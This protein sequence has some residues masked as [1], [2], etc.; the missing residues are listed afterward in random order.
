MGRSKK[1]SI[2]IIS[3]LTLFVEFLSN[4]FKFL[5]NIGGNEEMAYNFFSSLDGAKEFAELIFSKTKVV[6]EKTNELK[7][8]LLSVFKSSI[9][10]TTSAFNKSLFTTSSS[11]KY[12]ILD[13]FENRVLNKA[14]DVIPEFSGIL[15]SLKLTENMCDSEIMSEIGESNIFSIYEALGII[16][17]LT[18]RQ[19]KG[20]DGDIL[21]NGY[22][23]I[24]YVRI[25]ENTILA[26]GVRW[27]SAYRR[28]F[29][30]AFS[31][32]VG[33]PWYD[34]RCVLVRG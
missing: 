26:T 10:I 11:P 31:F 15:K 2:A 5:K 19:P 27:R 23:N 8:K 21:N 14:G 9:S 22:A 7:L 4:V 33:N 3:A 24:I 6:V 30:N 16:K 12:Y 17:V 18:E 20:E 34:G 1:S 28:W 13:N 32:D 25:D 29:L